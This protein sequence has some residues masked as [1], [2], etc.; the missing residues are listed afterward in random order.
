MNDTNTMLQVSGEIIPFISFKNKKSVIYCLGI[1]K[2]VAKS[3]FTK[4]QGNSKY[5][6]SSWSL[7]GWREVN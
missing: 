7:G 3:N 4:S 6:V 1:N 2:N 5:K